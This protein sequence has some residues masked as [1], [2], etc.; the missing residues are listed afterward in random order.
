MDAYKDFTYD[1]VNYPPSEVNEF[2][3]QLHDNHQYYVLITDPG[4]HNE[5]GYKPWD[6]GTYCRNINEL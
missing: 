5:N 4:I 6:E 3:N 1:P 2:V